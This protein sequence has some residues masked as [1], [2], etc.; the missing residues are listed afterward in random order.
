MSHFLAHLQFFLHT[1]FLTAAST[2]VKTT[3]DID[4]QLFFAETWQNHRRRQRGLR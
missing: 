2:T 4:K 1:R 3:K